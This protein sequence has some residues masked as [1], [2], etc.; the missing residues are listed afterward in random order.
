VTFHF[1]IFKQQ[2]IVRSFPFTL[3][4][5]GPPRSGGARSAQ[6]LT[7]VHLDKMKSIAHKKV[8]DGS[9]ARLPRFACSVLTARPHRLAMVL[10][11]T[12][13]ARVRTA[14]ASAATP[15]SGLSECLLVE[16]SGGLE[17]EGGDMFTGMD[18]FDGMVW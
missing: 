13:A 10:G 1:F 3:Q 11:L 7:L 2:I 8:G 17:V 14:P 12:R 15:A 6:S 16:G 18:M 9:L 4:N 5:V